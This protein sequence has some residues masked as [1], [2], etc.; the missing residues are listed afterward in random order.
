[1][2]CLYEER[3]EEVE[4]EE[5]EDLDAESN[6]E[7][8]NIYKLSS[9]DK[10]EPYRINVVINSMEITME[11]DTGASISVINYNTYLKLLRK[12]RISLLHRMLCYVRI[13]E[14]I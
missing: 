10:Q 8:F 4:E 14:M 11:I 13:R 12:S 5:K 1:M 3:A 9:G 7:T 2:L 6:D